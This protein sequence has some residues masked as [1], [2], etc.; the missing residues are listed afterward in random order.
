[1]HVMAQIRDHR[2]VL[3]G[4]LGATFRFH[5]RQG[6]M[7]LRG[8]LRSTRCASGE[9]GRRPRVVAG[10]AATGPARRRTVHRGA[11]P[12]LA[13]ISSESLTKLVNKVHYVK[14]GRRPLMPAPG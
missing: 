9:P 5:W 12:S 10:G 8:A 2:G 4:V 11:R 3:V 7:D 1:M 14:R 13:E 6:V